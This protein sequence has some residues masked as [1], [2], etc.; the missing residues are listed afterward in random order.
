MSSAGERLKE[1]HARIAT[2][3]SR[4]GRD[5]A[6]VTL[7]AV[8]K[9]FPAEAISELFAAG[10]KSFAES[11]QQEADGKLPLAPAGI[12][13]HFIGHLQRN[14]VR[15]VLESFGTLHGIDS[16]RLA[17]HVSSV[18]G[19][20]GMCPAIYLQV[21]IA[22]EPSKYGFSPDELRSSIAELA[23]LPNVTIRGLMG[24]PPEEESP[25]AARRWFAA[26]RGLRDELKGLAGAELADLSMGMSGDFEIAIEEGASIVRVGSA[27]FGNRT[28]QPS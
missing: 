5:P 3:A 8:S 22:A 7:L 27:L 26:L 11:R 20:L 9:T 6:D 15:K 23:Q 25:E 12:D 16:L 28:Y 4:A 13:W 17:Q 24:I 19:E 14:K 10:Q 1:I 2:A 21:N 18:A